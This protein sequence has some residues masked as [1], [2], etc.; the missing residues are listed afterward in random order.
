MIDSVARSSRVGST[1][2]RLLS[3][4]TP[5][6][7]ELEEEFAEFAGVEAAL[8]FTSGYAANVGLLSSL[9]QRGDIDFLRCA[10]SCKPD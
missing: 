1:G 2:S 4:H 8:Y 7:Q 6:W 10:E 3:G 9:L 5:E